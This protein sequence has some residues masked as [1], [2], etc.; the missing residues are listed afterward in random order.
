MNL[1][2]QRSSTVLERTLT[3]KLSLRN[4]AAFFL[5]FLMVFAIGCASTSARSFND[6][7]GDVLQGT[8]AVVQTARTLLAAKKISS[9]DAENVVKAAEVA[10][11]AV[12]VARETAARD[13]QVAG[14]ARLRVAADALDKLSAYLATKKGS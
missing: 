5:A 6:Y 1:F 13:G 11:D 4:P 3:M 7:A 9:S 2:Y 12:K 14:T 10:R 8:D